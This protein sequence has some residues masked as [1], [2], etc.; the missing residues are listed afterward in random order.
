MLLKKFKMIHQLIKESINPEDIVYQ[1][2]IL[3]RYQY[4]NSVTGYTYIFY[5][6]LSGH[7]IDQFDV[8]RFHKIT[9]FTTVSLEEG[10]DL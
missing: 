1:K 10:L 5:I 6:E 7:S 4:T 3:P 2:R 9:P 8:R